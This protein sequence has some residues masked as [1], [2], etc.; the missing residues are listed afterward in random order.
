MRDWYDSFA[1]H[2]DPNAE[3][4]SGIPRP[5][6]DKYDSDEQKVLMMVNQTEIALDL[7]TNHDLTE[8]CEFWREHSAIAQN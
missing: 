5:V 3:A 2:L 8:R 6:W 7:D 1:I 4:W